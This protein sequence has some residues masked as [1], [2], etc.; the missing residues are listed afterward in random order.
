MDKELGSTFFELNSL[1]GPITIDHLRAF[2]LHLN[3]MGTF[4]RKHKFQDYPPLA[5][6]LGPKRVAINIVLSHILRI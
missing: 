1:I 4:C 3:I 5:Y 6:G 2:I